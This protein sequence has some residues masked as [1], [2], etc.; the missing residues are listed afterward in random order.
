MPKIT[1][2]RYHDFS[3]G[4]RVYR[5]ESKCAHLHGHNGRV[6][7][8]VEAENSLQPLDTIGRVMDFSAIKEKLCMWLEDNWDHKTLIF[9][10]DPWAEP[11]KE[12]DPTLVIVPFVPT[13]ENMAKYLVET[14]GPKQLEG[15]G[16]VL[17]RCTFEET[18]KCCATFNK[19]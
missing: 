19:E 12:L 8:E 6:T 1:A 16:I 2:T 15:T 14:I 18:R 3:Y 13:A 7:F 4:H 17:K 11:L 10:D 9:K 5:H